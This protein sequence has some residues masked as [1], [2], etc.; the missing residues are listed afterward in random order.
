MLIK[1]KDFLSYAEWVALV[2][3][4]VALGYEIGRVSGVVSIIVYAIAAGMVVLAVSLC[5]KGRKARRHLV[6]DSYIMGPVMDICL[7]CGLCQILVTEEAWYWLGTA[8][9]LLCAIDLV[10]WLLT[11]VNEE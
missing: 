7:L 1:F 3:L 6:D 5:R 11:F 10:R 4:V 9:V 2:L 8:G